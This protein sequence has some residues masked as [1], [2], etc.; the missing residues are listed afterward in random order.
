MTQMKKEQIEIEYSLRSTS[1]NLIWRI[2]STEGGLQKWLADD[3]KAVEDKFFFTW[4]DEWRH[5]EKRCA[6]KVECIRHSHI[7]LRW[8]DETDPDAYLELRMV[9]NEMT[10]G[11]S[12]HVTD[13]ALPE[14]LDSLYDIWEQNFDQLRL[15][16]GL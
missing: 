15:N 14:D 7:R 16:T 11:Y 6:N 3:V 2:I 5:Q 9:H 1:P 13:F 12:L 10:D 4:G 8:D